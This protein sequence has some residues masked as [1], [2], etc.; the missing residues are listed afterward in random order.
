MQGQIITTLTCPPHGSHVVTPRTNK[1]SVVPHVVFR[2]RSLVL[3]GRR[4]NKWHLTDPFE[5]VAPHFQLTFVARSDNSAEEEGRPRWRGL[6]RPG[7]L[8]QQPKRGGRLGCACFAKLA[9]DFL[10]HHCRVRAL[11][12]VP[13]DHNSSCPANRACEEPP[14]GERSFSKRRNKH[15]HCEHGVGCFPYTVDGGLNSRMR[16]SP[17]PIV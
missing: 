9:S 11:K 13:R 17:T 4:T 1:L 2:N 3:S 14:A 12:R 5:L 7:L 10:R 6:P 8:L 15:S 16:P